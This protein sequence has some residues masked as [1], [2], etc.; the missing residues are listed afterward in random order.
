MT[1]S[2]HDLKHPDSPA[3]VKALTVQCG[4]CKVSAG[5]FCHAIGRGKRMAALVHYERAT[6]D[7]DRPKKREAS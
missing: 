3:V 2:I 4:I 5:E 1:V 7:M 6:R